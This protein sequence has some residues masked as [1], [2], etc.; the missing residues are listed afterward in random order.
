MAKCI[1]RFNWFP[2]LTLPLPDRRHLYSVMLTRTSIAP[3]RLG[4]RPCRVIPCRSSP[5]L[6]R[7]MKPISRTAYIPYVSCRPCQHTRFLSFPFAH[8]TPSFPP[9]WY[10]V[11]SRQPRSHRGLLH[12]PKYPMSSLIRIASTLQAPE[13]YIVIMAS[14][15]SLIVVCSDSIDS[16]SACNDPY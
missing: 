10:S 9:P 8:R 13:Q 16:H 7:D 5:L 14:I 1:Y 11:F 3:D 12:C 2:L 15:G 4:Y 6:Q